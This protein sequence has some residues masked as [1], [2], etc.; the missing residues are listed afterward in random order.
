MTHPDV[1]LEKGNFGVFTRTDV[2][3]RASMIPGRLT[4]LA[5]LELPDKSSLHTI[6]GFLNLNEGDD[7]I[8]PDIEFPLVKNERWPI[9]FKAVLL[10]ATTDSMPLP[11]TDKFQYNG[12][13]YTSLVGRF[14]TQ[15]RKF[16]RVMSVAAVNMLKNALI[17]FDYKALINARVTGTLAQYRKFDAILRT[18][19][20]NV[21]TAND[22][23][24]YIA[25]P[26]TNT[27]VT[28]SII[29][30]AFSEIKQSTVRIHND[31]SFDFLIHLLGYVQGSRK[32]IPAK[33]YPT[34]AAF[35]K[36]NKEEAPE[37]NSTSLFM[38]IPEETRRAINIVLYAGDKCIIY[39]LGDLA[40]FSAATA[41]FTKRV[42]K[43]INILKM[44]N[45]SDEAEHDMLT[46]D[47]DAL[48]KHIADRAPKDDETDGKPSEFS[49]DVGVAPETPDEATPQSVDA[50]AVVT[51]S[52]TPDVKEK[53]TG[54]IGGPKP[55]TTITPTP[56]AKAPPPKA[57]AAPDKK[58]LVRHMHTEIAKHTQKIPTTD[59][60]RTERKLETLLNRHMAAEI[61]GHP[62][63]YH[64]TSD[65]E[66]PINSA[67]LDFLHDQLPEKSQANSTITE[68]DPSYIKN[69]NTRDIA[70]TLASFA[71]QGMYISS[72]DEKRIYTHL[73]RRTEYKVTYTD[74]DGKNHSVPFS[75]PDVDENGM[76][77]SNGILTR[78]VP[79]MI[80]VPICKISPTR[81]SL[82]SNFN[83]F[84][85][86][87]HTSVRNSY[88]NYISSYLLQLRSATVSDENP[89][90][91]L[92]L[93]MGRFVITEEVLPYEYTA[94]NQKIVSTDF[95]GYSLVFDYP[96][97]LD[98][99]PKGVTDK[100][101]IALEEVNGVYC[102]TDAAGNLLFWDMH[103]HIHVLKK[104]GEQ[105]ETFRDFVA[106]LSNVFTPL[107]FPPPPAVAEWVTLKI[108]NL[109]IPLVIAMGYHIGLT[110]IIKDTGAK[111]RVVEKG[112]RV[113]LEEDEL[114]IPFADCTLV[115]SRH[116][117]TGYLIL[118]GLAKYNLKKY[119]LSQFEDQDVY[120]RLFQ[121]VGIRTNFLV[122][123]EHFFIFFLD[124]TTLDVLS[125]MHEP[126][127][128]TG[129]LYRATQML[130]T[131]EFVEASSMVHHRIRGYE[132]FSGTLYN[133]I[134]RGLADYL[135]RK[136][137]KRSFSV[138]PEAVYQRIVQD[139]TNNM[140][141]N[142][143]P[144]YEIKEKSHLS[145]TGA[146]GRTSRAFTTTDRRYPAD[147]LGI[148]SEATPDSGKV[149]ITAYAP[150]D[151]RIA[152]I[153][154]MLTPYKKGDKL[155]ATNL[156]SVAGNL[157]AGTHQDDP[158]R[159][160]YTSI[161]LTHHVPNTNSQVCPVRTG[162]ERTIAHRVS[163]IFAHSAK[164]DGVV[165]DIDEKTKFI[166]VQYVAHKREVGDKLH[167][168]Y[169]AS[170]IDALRNEKQ[171]FGIV[172]PA[173]RVNDYQI[174]QLFSVTDKTDAVVIERIKFARLE[175]VPDKAAAKAARDL[176]PAL[177][178]GAEDAVY[179]IRFMPETN[180]VDGVIEC[181]PFGDQ[182]TS[183]SGFYLKQEV[184]PNVTKGEKLKRG[185]IIT[186]NKGFF[187]QDPYT[188][189]VDWNHGRMATIA[190]V[191]M[192]AT[193]EDGCLI[194]SDFSKM[195]NMKPAHLRPV[196]V[197]NDSVIHSIVSVG[198]HVETTDLLCVVEAGDMF[199]SLG[200]TSNDDVMLN[201]L[202]KL[203]RRAPKAKHHGEVVDIAIYYSCPRERL[204]P[205]ILKLVKQQERAFREKQEFA[206]GS[207]SD[208][209]LTSP[210]Y[211]KPGTKH[212]GVEFT[213]TTVVIEFMIAE[214][215]PAEAGD[216]LVVCSANKTIIT[217][218]TER[219]TFTKSGRRVDMTF[220]SVSIM[221]RI[222][223]SP[224]T[225]GIG[226]VNH[227]EL[228]RQC[229]EEFFED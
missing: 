43:H 178:S 170:K 200:A 179:Y 204:S 185:D 104:D 132:R 70:V 225:V 226:S 159:A 42:L 191:E 209:R 149:A 23:H 31:P 147:G 173:S 100:A 133:E 79:Q 115:V 3:Y 186:Y 128:V 130:S 182:H 35:W 134:A 83:K 120:F 91:L 36:K 80:N 17:W 39:N 8:A 92:K 63:G 51:P 37:L 18:I 113:N 196:T 141:D 124:P 57:F 177:K 150:I 168:P 165:V 61:G 99:L 56:K 121:D 105:I 214:D 157:M 16:H 44:A 123:V 27:P 175:D 106:L 187:S 143:N 25:I 148:L 224:F 223:T 93:S 176:E 103:D 14:Y 203:D 111:T 98:A 216:K 53:P 131:M 54:A 38:R 48:D 174:G 190:L 227:R 228:R 55:K 140:V 169:P 89:T 126:T 24:H 9:Y 4:A 116:P 90:G 180:V 95:A 74:I 33:P 107:G 218:V 161:Q 5:D 207:S 222:V 13:K 2:A 129:L 65:A 50:P 215:I 136:G 156:F 46:M 162:F 202:A 7:T 192:S 194:D 112:T 145:H 181:I 152:N 119:T 97:R 219:P 20:D 60:E 81:V 34:D 172:I 164:D 213:D 221:A 160:N 15:H 102:G 26:L 193:L 84:L 75:I 183:V 71:R 205:S 154:G 29:E 137:Q 12:T 76:M 138:H 85:V 127:T 188:K 195:M 32:P 78:M 109:S 96:H 45:D 117:F 158:K 135:A 201:S 1:S 110:Q 139:S 94:L 59:K 114:A 87:R 21:A 6:T 153:R 199:M 108:Q 189:Q 30:P 206:K 184:V 77:L 62:I 86:E 66:K 163:D 58:L 217:A 197:Q 19:L 122:G 210:G 144:V 72:I 40:D 125:R 47:D 198:T 41:G 151:P 212:S 10:M 52:T 69:M 171:P 73:D 211:L 229:V 64:L 67:E 101:V 49:S 82:A 208:G 68:F 142:T 22:R 118:A 155:D 28:P 11:L 146:M 167:T 220:S 166:K 88:S